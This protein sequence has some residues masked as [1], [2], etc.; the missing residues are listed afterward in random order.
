MSR[1]R[2]RLVPLT[3]LVT[4][5]AVVPLGAADPP[6]IRVSAPTVEATDS[7]G[8]DASYHVKAYDPATHDPIAATCD[9]PGGTAGSGD[10]DSPTFHYPLGSTTVTCT[11]TDSGASGSAAV[12]VQDTTAPVLSLPGNVSADATGPTVVTYTEPTAND[13]VDGPVTPTCSS[14]SGDTFPVG[15][16]TVTCTAVDSHNNSVSASFTV[17][18]TVAAVD[19]PP[20]LS[21]PA[22]FDVHTSDPNGAV[23]PYTAT[24]N[25]AE[26]GALT[27]ACTPA[28]GSQFIVGT[29]TV[30]CSVTDSAGHTVNG[31]FSVTVVL[32]APPPP[33]DMTPPVL[34]NVPGNI[35]VE[36]NSAG[37]SVVN[38]ATPIAV[39]DVDGPTLVTCTPAAGSAFPLGTTTDT[40]S[41]TDSHGNTGT[42]SFT[43]RVVDTTPPHLIPPGDR[44]VYATTP[45]GIYSTDVAAAEF[46]GGASVSDIADAHPIVSSNAPSFFRVGPTDVTFTARDASGNTATASARLTVLPM[47]A[48]GTTP[49][50][51]PPPA[52][53]TPPSDVNDLV[54][55]PG[56]GLVTLRWTTPNAADFDHVVITRSLTT[57]G[58]APTTVY[59]GK[60]TSFADTGVENGIEYRYVVAAVDKAGNRSGG[61][62]VVALPKAAMLLSPKS[63]AHVKKTVKFRWRAVKSAKYYNL[64]VF[65]SGTG[66]L[67]ISAA[68][69]AKILSVWPT[70][71]TFV[72]KQK[73]K[74][75]RK[76]YALKPGVYTWYV[77]PGFGPRSAAEY[78][79][80]IGSST[81]TV[82]R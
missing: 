4:A 32:D 47:P 9:I 48:A 23:V 52:D 21:L 39:D 28:S 42:A 2:P 55:I 78:G 67:A 69:D 45:D 53:R 29:T 16:T 56:D 19:Q 61:V 18:V 30:T 33:S 7:A 49:P 46:V 14:H 74:Y 81:F 12:V 17:T 40:C 75:L 37:G 66:T 34:S 72:L 71:T 80:L 68:A 73:W 31:S 13:L 10:F 3:V 64:Q 63:G 36:A 15:S 59:S 50:P 62:V 54:A 26:D 58:A 8:A 1:I 70:R 11:A 82:V 60:D 5:I 22:N 24:A 38:F 25:D 44:S 57:A 35:Q 79:P 77:W 51:L 6:A 65:R 43:V 27:P 41:A 76:K 20:T